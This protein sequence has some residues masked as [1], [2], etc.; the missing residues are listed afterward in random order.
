MSCLRDYNRTRPTDLTLPPPQEVPMNDHPSSRLARRRS[1]CHPGH[2]LFILA[3]AGSLVWAGLGRGADFDHAPIN[4]TK[5]T[6]D[7]RVSELQKKLD[8]GRARL[9]Y[10]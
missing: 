6:P 4:Y 5:A 2:S 10:R 3:L 8:A 9:A 1:P 7:N